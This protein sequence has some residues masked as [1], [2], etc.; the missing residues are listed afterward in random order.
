M[1]TVNDHAMVEYQENDEFTFTQMNTMIH[2]LLSRKN[3]N[4]GL[5]RH[6]LS[7]LRLSGSFQHFW[8]DEH[9]GLVGFA[10]ERSQ[11]RNQYH[12]LVSGVSSDALVERLNNPSR[13]ARSLER[14]R[15]C[16]RE[17]RRLRALGLYIEYHSLTP[18]PLLGASRRL[19]Q[20]FRNHEITWAQAVKAIAYSANLTTGD[21]HERLGESLDER[22]VAT[23]RLNGSFAYRV[24]FVDSYRGLVSASALVRI[25]ATNANDHLAHRR[26]RSSLK[27]L[28]HC[29]RREKV[30]SRRE[31]AAAKRGYR[32]AKIL[33]A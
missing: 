31:Y 23:F 2:R 20:H 32:A 5:G 13:H 11:V 10:G 29:E 16:R 8:R 9:S 21:V 27:H 25:Y 26:L 15:L 12:L 33:C 3:R 28:L 22:G 24:E 6:L 30:K 17:R 7:K 4:N 18:R 14:T 19:K 1:Y